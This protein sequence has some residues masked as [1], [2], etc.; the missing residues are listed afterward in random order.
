MAQTTVAINLEAKTKG[1]ESVKSLKAQIREATQEATALAQKF[2]EFSPQAINAAKRVAQLKDEMQDFQERVQALNP[3][4]F[5]AIGKL[6]G[7]VANGIQAAQG[8]MALFGS[9]SEDVQK[10]LLRVQGAMAL[11]QGIQGVINAKNQ[12]KAFGK[13]VV[14]FFGKMTA[15]SK[16]FITS[17][18]GLLI[19]ALGVVAENWDSIKTAI[20]LTQKS[21]EDL[22]KAQQKYNS[23]LEYTARLVSEYTRDIENQSKIEIS[24]AKKRGA[25]NAEILALETQ[26]RN[27]LI[28]LAEQE[29]E[30]NRIKFNETIKGLDRQSDAY[31]EALKTFQQTADSTSTTIANLTA[32]NTIA[33]N[34]YTAQL[35]EQENKRQEE[36]VK[37]IKAANEEA[38]KNIEASNKRERELNL[39]LEQSNINLS[40]EQLQRMQ[41][42]FKLDNERIALIE[43]IAAIEDKASKESRE[44]TATEIALKKR[45]QLELEMFLKVQQ[46]ELTKF[47]EEQGK[48]RKEQAE[49]LN[50][51]RLENFKQNQSEEYNQA[52]QNTDQ[53]FLLER[54]KLIDSGATADE[55]EQLEIAR[56]QNQ[57]LNAQDYGQKTIDI[58]NQ[59]IEKKNALYKKDVENKKQAEQQMMQITAQGFATIAELADAFAGKSEEQQ[60]KA[61]EIKKKASMAQAVV[62]TI[63]AAQ[64]AYAWS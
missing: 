57:L 6:V 64:S 38:L 27:K 19:V 54:K 37:L 8:A 43:M 36:R 31:K 20:G 52:V 2:G 34:N 56:L 46:A 39:R 45:L 44:L 32:E 59:I 12:F 33:Q 41:L 49:E 28:K 30:T 5:E 40:E 58:E 62:E 48:K 7:G 24:N 23:E 9:E 53:F 61:F 22:E 63:Q 3:D 1:T 21:T 35:I 13:D 55:L 47:E 17:G 18:I 50:K 60:R 51:Q 25:T 4:K 14:D 15:Q 16:I 10:M 29:Q 11:A 26:A 42:E